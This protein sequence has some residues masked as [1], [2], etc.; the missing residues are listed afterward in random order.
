MPPRRSHVE[1]AIIVSLLFLSVFLRGA[2]AGSLS[3]KYTDPEQF[4]KIPFGSHS[5]WAQPWR[6]YLE[7]MPATTFLNGTGINLNLDGQNPDLIA[8]MLSR[9]GIHHARIEIGWGNI[10]QDDE[11]QL[12]NAVSIGDTLRACKKFGLRPLILLNAHQGV[13]CP[14]VSVSRHVT[15]A[16]HKGD[17]TVELD[18][19]SGLKIG[20]S[21]LSNLTTYW[22]AESLITKIDGHTVTLSKPLPKEIPAG[23]QVSIATLSYRPFSQPGTE[24][25]KATIA[26]WQH[27]VDTIAKFA[28]YVLG[29]T[30]KSD[31][32]FDMEIWNELTF[33]SQFLSIN[34]YYSPPIV[35]Y[36]ENAIWSGLVAA[37]ASYAD[38][39]PADFAG[40]QFGDGFANTIPWPASSTEP[41]RIAAIDK[42]PYAGRAIY[43]KDNYKGENLNALYRAD[44]YVPT[45]TALFPEYYATALQTETIVRD[46]APIT[47]EIYGTKHGRSAR[48]VKG[49][50]V[51][52]QTWITETNIAPN[53]S[54]PSITASRAAEVK[55]KVA[56]RDFCFFLNKGVTQVDLFAAAGGDTGL[57]LVQDNFLSYARKP[58][59]AYPSDDTLSTSPALAAVGR[60]AGHMRTDLDST[61]KHTRPLKV[62]SLRDTHNH[63]QFVGDG[64]AAHPS[65]YDRDVFAFLPYQ[66]N[67]A[68]FVIPYYVMTRDIMKDLPAELFTI[69]IGG[70]H[71]KNAIVKAYD[72]MQ[73]TAVPLTVK[74]R[75]DETITLIVS[76][77]DYPRL[78]TIQ[79]AK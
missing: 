19:T 26:G 11:T 28:A 38:A 73:N 50:I 8:E 60:I 14:L 78:L 17:T 25:Y 12:N 48:I 49:K 41:A 52:C 27:Y 21:G 75:T 33:G 39:H 71:G 40:V 35:K 20:Y 67:A 15:T 5:H 56:I 57:G 36:D 16:A 70:I 69:K 62:L 54:Q 18:D 3:T 29:T 24:D 51:P 64:T 59:I 44:P 53:E 61:L 74:A 6:A 23:T 47:N 68:R 42:H 77:T 30:T 34:N 76:A 31:K 66:V 10:N 4:T 13:P 37:T 1:T 65:L 22:A 7:T 2:F 58:S 46:M 63:T 55:A 72:P 32:G 79:E 9:H 43:P 45:Y